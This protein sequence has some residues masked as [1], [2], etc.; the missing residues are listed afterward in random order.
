[1]PSNRP[2]PSS[3]PQA[4]AKI[5]DKQI[6][7][8]IP[9]SAAKEVFLIVSSFFVGLWFEAATVATV[10]VHNPNNAICASF[11]FSESTLTLF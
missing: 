2:P 6:T 10:G 3:D 5:A 1:M 9:P 7:S 8:A 4:G 11:G